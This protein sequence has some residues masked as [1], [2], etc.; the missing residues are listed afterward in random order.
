[1]TTKHM[2]KT[3]KM[4]RNRLF[5]RIV[6]CV[7]FPKWFSISSFWLKIIDRVGSSFTRFA[8]RSMYTRQMSVLKQSIIIRKVNPVVQLMPAASEAMI[9]LNGLVVEKADPTEEPI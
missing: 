6:E 7:E 8:Y 9:E 2:M 3:N 1:M 5:N 4:S